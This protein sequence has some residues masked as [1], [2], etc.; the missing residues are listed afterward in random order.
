M[1]TQPHAAEQQTP[2]FEGFYLQVRNR[3]E[4]ATVLGTVAAALPGPWNF[5]PVGEGGTDYEVTSSEVALSVVEAWEMTYR[6]RMLPGVLYAEPLFAVTVSAPPAESGGP[7]PPSPGSPRTPFPPDRSGDPDPTRSGSDSSAPLPESERP[8]WIFQQMRIYEAWAKFPSGLPGAGIVI[9]HPDTGYRRHPE[10]V[11]NLLLDHGMDFIDEDEDPLDE[12]DTGRLLFP[13][14]GT[15]TAS[16]IISPAPPPQPDPSSKSV[17]GIAPGAKL[18]PLRVSRSVIHISMLN[19]A[20]AIEYAVDH[21]AHVISMSLGGLF[22]RRLRRAIV[23]AQERGVIIVSAAGNN[24]RYVVWP[25]AYDEVI[26][27]AASNARRVPWEGSSRG[28]AVDV[29]APGE[30]VWVA[31]VKGEDAYGVEQSSGTSFATAAVA[32]IAALWLSYHGRDKLIARYGVEKIPFIFNQLLRDTCDAVPWSAGKYGMG[33][34]NAERLL[35]AALPDGVER[36]VAPPSL[37]LQEHAPVDSGG[38]ETFSHLFARTEADMFAPDRSFKEMLRSATDLRPALAELLRTTPDRVPERLKEVGQELAFHMAV[39]PELYRAFE[40]A[41]SFGSD[42]G[43][44]GGVR[45]VGPGGVDVVRGELLLSGVS[46]VLAVKV[47]DP[48]G[49]RG[50]G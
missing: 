23:Y 5:K 18:I 1:S 19:V 30:S 12:L 13:G 20:N 31:R 28:G 6:L 41:I 24:V 26:A 29:T 17:S 2:V 36:S 21:G 40:A 38:L 43:E 3:D 42:A 37:S 11:D 27:V 49:A 47:G 46:D 7:P 15:A 33:I 45:S 48:F 32:G 25:A 22:S 8:D 9:G 44:A 50:A 39:N 16:V 14:H 34:V 4:A 10:I 35:D